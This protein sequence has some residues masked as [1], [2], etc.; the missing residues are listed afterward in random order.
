MPRS[1]QFHH[2]PALRWRRQQSL[3]PRGTCYS[4]PKIC[5]SRPE[6]C[7]VG[8][9]QSARPFEFGRLGNHLKFRARRLREPR[10]RAVSGPFHRASLLDCERVKAR[11]ILAHWRINPGCR[12]SRF[13]VALPSAPEF[14]LCAKYLFAAAKRGKVTGT[15]A[16]QRRMLLLSI[17]LRRQLF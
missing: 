5:S 13:L 14:L 4:S 2:C 3:R 17:N 16:A 9:S 1:P 7:G 8:C 6:L 15:L 10:S 12:V 11:S